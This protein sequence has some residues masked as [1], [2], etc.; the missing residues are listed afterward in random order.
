MTSIPG[1]DLSTWIWLF[2]AILTVLGCVV[3][4]IREPCPSEHFRD[5]IL[6]LSAGYEQY[7]IQPLLTRMALKQ[8]LL[9]ICSIH[10][11]EAF[12]VCC[13]NIVVV[14]FSIGLDCI[15]VSVVWLDGGR[16][17]QYSNGYNSSVPSR[18]Y[19]GGK[20]SIMCDLLQC[21][22]T[23][24]CVKISD[25]QTCNTDTRIEFTRFKRKTHLLQ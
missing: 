1:W 2:V 19:G 15:Y 13:E 12:I 5:R 20:L 24:F 6:S 25:W 3:F 16:T 9:T 10:N 14:L 23:C 11:V 18:D 8:N 4:N 7:F 22:S 21:C 17:S